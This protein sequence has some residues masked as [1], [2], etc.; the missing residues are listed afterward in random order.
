MIIGLSGEE[1]FLLCGLRFAE[2]EDTSRVDVD[3]SGIRLADPLTVLGVVLIAH[4]AAFAGIRPCVKLPNDLAETERLTAL[5]LFEHLEPAWR[6]GLGL[7]PRRAPAFRCIPL[8]R[9]DAHGGGRDDFVSRCIELAGRHQADLR[10]QRAIGQVLAEIVDNAIVHARSPAGTYGVARV[11]LGDELDGPAIVGPVADAPPVE[12]PADRSTTVEMAGP[13][14]EV[15]G[16]AIEGAAIEVAIGDAGVGIAGTLGPL[17]PHLVDPVD[18]LREAF[19]PRVSGMP[20]G[21]PHCGLGLHLVDDLVH[22]RL[23]GSELV[24]LSDDA[25]GRLRACGPED[26]FGPRT[27]GCPHA[28]AQLARWGTWACL[29]VPLCA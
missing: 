26:H 3:L 10:L 16:P 11:Y 27:S 23:P 4:R 6:M 2:P 25:C 13:A 22:R 8:R 19:K 14:V 12:G 9:L 5:G 29:R 18:A 15:T 24:V 17:H 28:R 20:P 1:P 7:T 21:G